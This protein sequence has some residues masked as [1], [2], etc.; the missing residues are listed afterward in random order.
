MSACAKRRPISDRLAN[1]KEPLIFAA[2]W[3]L[4]FQDA[5]LGATTHCHASR[6]P[7]DD[8]T[9]LVCASLSFR[10]VV[11]E[12]VGAKPMRML[13]V[14]VVDHFRWLCCSGYVNCQLQE[15][16]APVIRPLLGPLRLHPVPLMRVLSRRQLKV[17][18]GGGLASARL[19]YT[20]HGE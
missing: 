13:S 3:Q 2:E 4:R 6:A 12:A 10:A 16:G 9:S 5:P 17:A 1:G 11:I 15:Q 7:S 20:G 14:I 18:G 8:G 19:I